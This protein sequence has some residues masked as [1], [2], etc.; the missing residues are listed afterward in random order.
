[1]WK[2]MNGLTEKTFNHFV[3]TLIEVVFGKDPVLPHLEIASSRPWRLFVEIM[4]VACQE[5]CEGKAD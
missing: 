3:G 1:M 5:I 2:S 4:V